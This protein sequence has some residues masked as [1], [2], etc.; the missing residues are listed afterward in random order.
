MPFWAWSGLARVLGLLFPV[1]RAAVSCGPR[2]L[3]TTACSAKGNSRLDRGQ[4]GPSS[5]PQST[6]PLE[7]LSRALPQPQSQSRHE[8]PGHQAA[9]LGNLEHQDDGHP[10]ALKACW[11]PGCGAHGGLC[12]AFCWA[13]PC[14]VPQNPSISPSVI[15]TMTVWILQAT[16]LG[17]ST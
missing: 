10:G 14:V 13:P 5:L 16:M 11:A 7:R 17:R 2:I 12:Q 15:G 8:T 6:G 9:P 3:D 1:H 4:T